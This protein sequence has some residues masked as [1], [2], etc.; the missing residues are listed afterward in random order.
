MGW[1]ARLTAPGSGWA[2]RTGECENQDASPAEGADPI[3]V[4]R[5]GSATMDSKR[6][7]EATGITRPDR[8]D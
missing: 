7:A 8:P 3:V 5:A 4:I 2:V 1:Y 6:G